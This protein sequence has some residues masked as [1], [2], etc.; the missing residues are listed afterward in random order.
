MPPKRD[1]HHDLARSLV[2]PERALEAVLEHGPYLSRTAVSAP[3]DVTNLTTATV[4]I[5]RGPQWHS[6]SSSWQSAADRPMAFATLV[7]SLLRADMI[8]ASDFGSP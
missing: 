7:A 3:D 5:R 6:F 1:S 8:S 2:D 4:F